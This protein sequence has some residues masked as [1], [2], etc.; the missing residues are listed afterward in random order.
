MYL[1]R[2]YWQSIMKEIIVIDRTYICTPMKNYKL[3]KRKMKNKDE[4]K[5]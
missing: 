2:R 1:M 3:E 5:K 4:K